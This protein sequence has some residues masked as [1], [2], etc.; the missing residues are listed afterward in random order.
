MFNEKSCKRSIP[1]TG[2]QA[3]FKG[4]LTE[5][6]VDL[7]P[8]TV[9]YF[10]A[11]V[12]SKFPSPSPPFRFASSPPPSP[13]SANQQT[14]TSLQNSFGIWSIFFTSHHFDNDCKLFLPKD[15][16]ECLNSPI[17]KVLFFRGIQSMQQI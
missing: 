14:V 17:I 3:I 8:V 15:K 12:H 11:T 7:L 5:R 4:F 13:L 1:K 6:N 16:Q 2:D 9:Y 10:A